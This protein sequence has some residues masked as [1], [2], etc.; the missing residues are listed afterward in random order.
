MPVGFLGWEYPLEEGTAPH[1]VFLPEESHGQRTLV[2]Y[3][4]SGHKE[5]DMTKATQH[6]HTHRIIKLDEV[7]H[8]KVLMESHLPVSTQ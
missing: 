2:G 6:I 7:I 4:P 3:S 8:V 5:L 1:S